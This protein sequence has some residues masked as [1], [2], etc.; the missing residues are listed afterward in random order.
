MRNHHGLLKKASACALAFV[1]AASLA[2]CGSAT[3]ELPEDMS[4]LGELVV[5]AREEGSGT[6]TTFESLASTDEEGTDIIASST[7]EVIAAVAADINA[8]G[9]I[10]SSAAADAE[11]VK[12]ID[13][14]GVSPTT[15]TIQKGSY[16]LMRTYYLAYQDNLSDVATDFLT[17]VLT[18]GQDI[19]A[20]SCVPVKSAQTFLSDQSEGT[21]VINGSSSVAPIMEELA[22]AYMELNENA[23]VEV[24]TSDSGT[25]LTAAIRGECDMAIS[26]RELE[27]YENELLESS[28]IGLD[29]ISI[30]VNEENPVTDLTL[31]MITGI[32]SKTWENWSDIS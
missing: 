6:R 29:G 15:E 9:Y 32:Y 3:A 1:L 7:D 18:A 8:I 16:A 12:V 14:N 21:V 10:A 30:I 19:V 13:I 23:V 24:V 2:G 25:G 4:M 22:Q 27:S 26:S 17:F 28:A 5:V 20:E 11:G 31:D